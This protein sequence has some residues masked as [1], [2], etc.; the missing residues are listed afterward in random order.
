MEITKEDMQSQLE[1]NGYVV[2]PN[3]LTAEEITARISDMKEWQKTIPDHDKI[4]NDIDPHGIYKHHGVGH[5]KHAWKIRINKTV[6]SYFAHLWKSDDLVVSFDGSCYIPKSLKKKDN[7][8]T[9]TDQAPDKKGLHCI[10]GFVALTSNSERTLVVYEKSH[11][12]HEKYFEDRGIKSTKN[13]FK[14]DHDY[15]K[16]IS[17]SKRI[18]TVPAGSLVLWDSRVFHQNQ[19]GEPNSEERMVQYV[20]YLP[21]DHPKYTKKVKEKREKYF[22]EL[23]TTSHW[24]Y[25]VI[26]NGL[27]P[28][29]Y[30]DES[31]KINYSELTAPNLKDIEHEIKKLL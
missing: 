25:P 27:Q 17:A 24:P 10:Q 6:Q 26:V 11:L 7:I 20:C 21:R 4:H 29:T 19:Y 28:Q 22:R 9:H 31:K 16:E 30:G 2:C 15:L 12:L 23:R 14:I 5:Q 13:W 18:L 8:W 1:S 3:V